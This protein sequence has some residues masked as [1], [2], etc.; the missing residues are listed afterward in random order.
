MFVTKIRGR[1]TAK[2]AVRPTFFIR[3]QF[4]IL[5]DSRI[6]Q[7]FICSVQRPHLPY[8]ILDNDM[9]ADFGDSN[10]NAYWAFATPWNNGNTVGCYASYILAETDTKTR[11]LMKPID[12]NP[13][14]SIF[15]CRFKNIF[16]D[17]VVIDMIKNN[18]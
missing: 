7:V 6:Q 12:Y 16:A 2:Y 11:Q 3:L 13:G 10:G 18:G 9:K 1:G 5:F 17:D 14:V 8:D 4:L 15:V